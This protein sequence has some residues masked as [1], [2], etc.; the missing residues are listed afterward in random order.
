MPS[1]REVD[2]VALRLDR[3]M[4]RSVCAG[5]G[6][7]RCP[8]SGSTNAAECGASVASNLVPGLVRV[9]QRQRQRQG[10]DR[11]KVGSGT[12]QGQ[13]RGK[14][15]GRD[16]GKIRFICILGKLAEVRR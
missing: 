13:R 12:G 2:T 4:L 15:N 3:Q 7:Y 6:G 9:R 16:R 5:G 14:G 11:G 1:P 10:R 8:E